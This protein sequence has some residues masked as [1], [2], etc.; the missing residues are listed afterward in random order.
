MR[1]LCPRFTKSQLSRGERPDRPSPRETRRSFPSGAP[2]PGA[3]ERAVAGFLD[4]AYEADLSAG[5][6]VAD[7]TGV[8][9]RRYGFSPL[10]VGWEVLGPARGGQVVVLELAEG[11]DLSAIEGRLRRLGYDAP[12]DGPGTDGT[13]QGGADLV[14]SIDPTLTPV[15]QN[16]AVVEDERLV[17]MSDAPGPVS[18]TV[19][20]IAGDEAG[21]DAPLTSVAGTPV[22]AWLWA[23]DFA[24]EDLTMSNADPEDQ[25]LASRLVEEAGGVN[26][27]SGLVMA[28]QP[29]DSV[30]IGM[31]FE[32]DDQASR[33]LQPRVDLAA[34]EAPGQGGTFEDGRHQ[35]RPDALPLE[36]RIDADLPGVEFMPEAPG[37]RST[38]WLTTLTI[39][40]ALAGVDREQVRLHLE[41]LD[42][43]ARPVWKPMHLQP[44]FAGRQ[45]QL[46]VR[47]VLAH[48]VDTV[49]AGHRIS[50]LGDGGDVRPRQA[51]G[52]ARVRRYRHC[53]A[54]H[55]VLD[56]PRG[57]D[58]AVRSQC[59]A[60]WGK[61]PFENDNSIVREIRGATLGILG[62]GGLAL[63]M[64]DA[65]S[66]MV[67]LGRDELIERYLAGEELPREQFIGA[68]KKA[69]LAGQIVPLF[70][71]SATL[72]Y[73]LRTLLTK[74]VE[75]LPSPAEVRPPHRT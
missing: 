49:D 18:A 6:A 19:S 64:E 14:A 15:M 59:R 31:R 35:L 29:D 69:M 20:V 37:N 46:G 62:L 42:I 51:Y 33:N 71:G 61:P 39:D 24:C 38:F 4:R 40:P 9:D 32:N 17:V 68:F 41:S 63:A 57:L 12:P 45:R 7:A 8:L 27:L 67:R 60:E 75:L 58:H 3:G 47:A 22:Q 54:E 53:E 34:G 30:T 43:E 16:M 10:D 73:G 28:R 36:L 26:P 56:R 5:S 55:A 70:C 50:V 11:A 74:M 21:L 66:R 25:R 1:R 23:D 2:G 65:N 13:W 48:R 44:V 72:T 52:G